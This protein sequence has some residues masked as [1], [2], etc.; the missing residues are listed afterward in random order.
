MVMPMSEP[1]C[2]PTVRVSLAKDV[3]AREFDGEWVVLDLQGGNYFGLDD[4]GGKVWS[5]LSTGRSPEEI[6]SLLAPEYD[7]SEA[8]LL[9]DVRVLVDEL[10]ERNLVR[11]DEGLHTAG[12]GGT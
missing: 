4:I 1:R 9:R 5:H 6:A 8:Q 10:L 3:S 11:L 12:T 7:V 2:S